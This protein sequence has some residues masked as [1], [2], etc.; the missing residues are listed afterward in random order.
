MVS[1]VYTLPSRERGSKLGP[2]HINDTGPPHVIVRQVGEVLN[3]YFPTC[4]QV[5]LHSAQRAVLIDNIKE[6]A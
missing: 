6:H 1:L 4:G 5:Y 2:N 3:F